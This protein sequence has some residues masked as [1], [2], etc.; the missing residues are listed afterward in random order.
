M[1]HGAKRMALP[2]HSQRNFP[3]GIPSLYVRLF[4][5]LFI[6]F[7]PDAPSQVA[8]ISRLIQLW[9]SP[10]TLAAFLHLV[11]TSSRLYV[12]A[13]EPLASELVRSAVHFVSCVSLRRYRQSFSRLMVQH[14]SLASFASLSHL[15]SLIERV[16]VSHLVQAR[17]EQALVTVVASIAEASGAL[18]TVSEPP[19][20]P[21]LSATTSNAF[22]KTWATRLLSTSDPLL[23][24]GIIQ[25]T[26]DLVRLCFLPLCFNL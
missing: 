17:G 11:L 20:T 21:T 24:C 10:D 4:V 8:Y 26:K 15:P 5:C 9:N 12:H 2:R 23:L 16:S 25:H 22:C 1:M 18:V 19:A 3:S 6:C 7:A 13:A 14:W